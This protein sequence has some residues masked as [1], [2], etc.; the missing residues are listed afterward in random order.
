MVVVVVVGGWGGGGGGGGG[1]GSGPPRVRIY[2]FS[3]L[4]TFLLKM[5]NSHVLTRI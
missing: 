5:H 2:R 4:S 1:G 3:F